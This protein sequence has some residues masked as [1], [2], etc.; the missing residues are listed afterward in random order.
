MGSSLVPP[1]SGS[2][3]V[4][5]DNWVLISSVTPT[6]SATTVVFSSIPLRKKLMLRLQSPGQSLAAD[7]NITF[8]GDTGSNYAL[9]SG[10]AQNL[11]GTTVGV[12]KPIYNIN[13]TS[14]SLT[15]SAGAANA[16]TVNGFLII[17]GTDTAGVKT[18]NGI[19][20]ST[21]AGGTSANYPTLNGAYFGSAVVSSVTLTISAGTYL[22]TG[23]IAL[24][25]VSA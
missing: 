16:L 12:T 15:T 3:S 21:S 5:S 19:S 17:Q 14:L 24:Y 20:S 25:G 10:A 8:N 9:N 13:G 18:L 23:S 6:A 4:A 7:L 2:A 22:A 11:N 1:A